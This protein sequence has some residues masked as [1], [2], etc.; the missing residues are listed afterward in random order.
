MRK[1]G[2][3]RPENW[4]WPPES[5]NGTIVDGDI[6]WDLMGYVTIKYDIWGLKMGYT[7]KMVLIVANNDDVVF[8]IAAYFTQTLVVN[9]VSS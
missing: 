1:D 5:C 6:R 3:S 4:R 2:F 8:F 9:P 7:P